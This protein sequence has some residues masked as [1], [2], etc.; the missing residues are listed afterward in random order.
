M[1]VNGNHGREKTQNYILKLASQISNEAFVYMDMTSRGLLKAELLGFVVCFLL[2]L[3]QNPSS[4]RILASTVAPRQSE[5]CLHLQSP[6][7][8][9]DGDQHLFFH[10]LSYFM[11]VTA[12]ISFQQRISLESFACYQI[13]AICLAQSAC[14]EEN[15]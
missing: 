2:W 12:I 15:L 14:Q 4:I 13:A 11:T 7:S 3:I 8:S 10:E 5:Q 9:C 6:N 1:P